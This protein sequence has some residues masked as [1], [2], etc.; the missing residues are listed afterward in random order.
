MAE[1]QQAPDQVRIALLEE[2]VRVLTE[3]RSRAL[4]EERIRALVDAGM[5]KCVTRQEWLPVR[6]IVYGL[7]S[8]VGLTVLAAVL[9]M[10]M[11]G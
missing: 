9:K 4:T 2:R 7:A 1:E 8:A 5:A 6:A 3:E 11:L 10:A